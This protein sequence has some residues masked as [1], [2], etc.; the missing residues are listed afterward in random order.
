MVLRQAVLVITASAVAVLASACSTPAAPPTKNAVVKVPGDA[1]TLQAAADRVASGGL[2]L[3]GPGTYEESVTLSTPD[4]TL[5]G[6]DRNKTIIDGGGIRPF[7]VVVTAD[8][9][10]VQNLTVSDNTFYGVLVTGLHDANGVHANSGDD[11][12]SFD[13][14]KFPPLQRFA[15]EYVTAHNN[16]LY[17]LYAF[18][19]QHGLI[20]NSYA[21]GSADSGLYVGQCPSCDILVRDN[22]AERNA[23]GF[24]NANASELVIAGNRFSGNRVGLT[25]LSDFQEAFRPERGNSVVGNVLSGNSEPDSP[26]QADGAFGL[27]LGIAGGVDNLIARN[28]IEA[29]PRAGVLLANTRNLPAQGNRFEGNTFGHNGVDV[30]NISASRAPAT[31]TC[32]ADEVSTLPAQLGSELRAGCAQGRNGVRLA[33]VT[34]DELP[35]SPPP[36]GVSFLKVAPPIDQPGLP[37]TATAT[38]PLPAR[39]TMP[40]INAIGRPSA[41]L[42]AD[43]TGHQ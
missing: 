7:G 36:A 1:T 42:L 28:R 40:D 26:T 20:A 12:E 29:N 16:G 24:E 6:V 21:S 10:R 25:L 18:D 15:I 38:P 32:V 13:P 23:V 5:R 9:V 41:G 17:G 22:V 35:A 39:M 27:G 37:P 43:L 2:I 14:A 4:V 34:V 8:G 30:A 11:D 19:A 3:V 31:D 33:A